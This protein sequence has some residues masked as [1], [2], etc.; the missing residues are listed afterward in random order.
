MGT[1]KPSIHEVD[2][3]AQMAS[4]VNQLIAANPAAFFPLRV[5]EGFPRGRV[6]ESANDTVKAARFQPT[7]G[8]TYDF[9]GPLSCA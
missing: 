8:S 1:T 9:A 3:C 2:F 7:S 5:A 6:V 4:A